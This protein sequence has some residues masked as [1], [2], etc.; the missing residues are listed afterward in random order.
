MRRGRVGSGRGWF[1]EVFL[2]MLD[3]EGGVEILGFLL[4]FCDF[5]RHIFRHFF[6]FSDLF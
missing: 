5:F 3:W 6:C 4:V 1:L 2:G